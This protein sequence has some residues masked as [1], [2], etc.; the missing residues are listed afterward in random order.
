MSFVVAVPEML[1]TAATD[2]ASLE[3]TISL[4]NAAAAAPDYGGAGRGGG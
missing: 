4:A 2:L 1:G 3:S